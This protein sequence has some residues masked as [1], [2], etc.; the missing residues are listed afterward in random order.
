MVLPCWLTAFAAD[1]QQWIEARGC[2]EASI[3]SDMHGAT[4]LLDPL[5][6]L[7]ALPGAI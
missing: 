2:A 5:S 6:Q 3:P 4:V 1:R 7:A